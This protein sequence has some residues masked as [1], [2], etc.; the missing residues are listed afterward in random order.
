MLGRQEGITSSGAKTSSGTITT[1]NVPGLLY[2]VI[3]RSGTTASKIELRNGGSGGTI[4]ATISYV[5]TTAVGDEIRGIS[6]PEP[7]AFS[8]DIYATIAGTGAEAYV[9]Y[10][11]LA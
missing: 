6:F 5:A 7:V 8:T 11:Q 4:L 10:K 3:L 2:A 9:F 1:A